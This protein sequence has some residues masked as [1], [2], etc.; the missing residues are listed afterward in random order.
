MDAI[1]APVSSHGGG[2]PKDWR[3]YGGPDVLE[4][5]LCRGQAVD[6]AVER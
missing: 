3:A 2:F 6:L 1:F 5:M 4:T